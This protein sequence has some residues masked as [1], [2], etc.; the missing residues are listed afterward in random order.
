M[1]LL[2][3]AS[4]AQG[5]IHEVGVSLGATNYVGDLVPTYQLKNHRLAGALLYRYNLSSHTS[6]R[7]NVMLGKLA[8]S[9]D[10]AYDA[11]GEARKRGQFSNWMNEAALLF[12]YN[13]LD[14]K[15]PSKDLV[16]WSPYLVAG[17][18]V[19][20]LHG[21]EPYQEGLAPGTAYARGR[22]TTDFKN[23]QPVVPLGLGVKY[24]LSPYWTLSGEWSARKTFFD[25][26]D[27]TGAIPEGHVAKDFQYGNI[28]HKDW[29]FFTGI[30]LSYTFWTIPCPY[31][32]DNKSRL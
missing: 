32:F 15:N 2:L 27:N 13:F 20:V 1:A 25:Y 24:R 7:A 29:Y 3:C 17:L 23:V 18:G 21:Y 30:S 14:Y 4:L 26:I 11:F 5:Q 12:E 10:P 31:L 8:G 9:D 6:L 28:S 16:R 22:K 19:L